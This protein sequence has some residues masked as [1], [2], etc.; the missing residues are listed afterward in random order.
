MKKVWLLGLALWLT[1]CSVDGLVGKRYEAERELWKLDWERQRLSIRPD[2]TRE[3]EWDRLGKRYEGLADRFW[4]PPFPAGRGEPRKELQAVTARSL[5]AAAEIRAV[6][7][8]SIRIAQIYDRIAR[9][10]ADY[11]EISGQVSLAQGRF[12]ENGGKLIAAADLYQRI[13]DSVEPEA[14]S[15]GIAGVV[16]DLPLKIAQLR[17]QAKSMPPAAAY[18]VAKTY[19]ERLIDQHPGDRIRFDAQARLAQAEA[20]LGE[21]GDALASLRGLEHQL[22]ATDRSGDQPAEVRL[23][24]SGLQDR[25]GAD[26]ESVRATLSSFLRDYPRS[27]RVPLALLALADNADRRNRVE[28]AIGYLDQVEKEHADKE[29]AVTQS[30]LL[31]GRILERRERWGEALEAFRTLTSA[32]PLS[33]EALLVPLEIADHYS[34]SKDPEA[35]KTALAQAEGSYRDFVA[36]YPANATTAF[37]RERLIQTLGREK[38]FD[39]AIDETLR[40]GEDLKGTP[41]GATLMIVAAGVAY[42]ELADTARAV[43]ILDHV[44]D[45]YSKAGVGS[46]ASTEAGRLRRMMSR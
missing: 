20:G 12:A 28:E 14:D 10:Y 41:R 23:A 24:I 19:Y 3:E 11:P 8:D 29:I 38:K 35:L 46:W 27:D 13:V 25:S 34:R 39:E 36:R 30:L 45:L 1:S 15:R 22:L 16:V 44:A 43:T 9:E 31:R 42:N 21:W 7:R 32:H 4:H 37:A 26:P 2:Q 18:G 17:V 5:F 40:L 6:L 33:E